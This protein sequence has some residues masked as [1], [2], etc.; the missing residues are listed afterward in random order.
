MAPACSSNPGSLAI[1]LTRDCGLWAWAVERL[2]P[3]DPL[4]PGSANG[5]ADA[6]AADVQYIGHG[7][8]LIHGGN[9]LVG[10]EQFD[11]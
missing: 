2:G 4:G 9:Q 5:S 1:K 10:A 3:A 11:P 8:D 7:A 6:G